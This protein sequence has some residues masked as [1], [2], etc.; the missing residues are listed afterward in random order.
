MRIIRNSFSLIT[1]DY[2]KSSIMPKDNYQGDP[3]QLD[4]GV[5]HMAKGHGKGSYLNL[6]N[7]GH[8]VV[9]FQEAF[10]QLN[11]GG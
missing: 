10:V 5:G 4:L 7:R 3:N 6:I 1:K 9:H 2:Y 8:G 11:Y